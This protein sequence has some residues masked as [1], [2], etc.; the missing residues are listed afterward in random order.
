MSRF[1]SGR[2]DLD[3]DGCRLTLMYLAPTR[4]RPDVDFDATGSFRFPGER[5]RIVGD[6]FAD[7]LHAS[8]G[9][10]AKSVSLSGRSFN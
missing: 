7:N 2:G 4:E 10:A 9:R 5:R 3:S 6:L 8:A 1:Y